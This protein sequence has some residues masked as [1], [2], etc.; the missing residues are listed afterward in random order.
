MDHQYGHHD[1]SLATAPGRAP[2]RDFVQY[3]HHAKAHQCEEVAQG[4]W[5]TTIDGACC[6]TRCQ[7]PV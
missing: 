3:T 5:R 2:R 4:T 6:P 7:A 1:Y